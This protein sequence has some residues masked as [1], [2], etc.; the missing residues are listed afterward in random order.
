MEIIRNGRMIRLENLNDE[1][2]RR[3]EAAKIKAEEK[4]KMKQD[5]A[6]AWDREPDESFDLSE[7][8]AILQSN[9]F[10]SGKLLNFPKV[11]KYQKL[12]SLSRWMDAKCQYVRG[13][14]CDAPAKSQKNATVRIDLAIMNILE[15][16]AAKVYAAM[17]A[18]ADDITISGIVNDRK[19]G[20]RCIRV[21]F[22]VQNVWET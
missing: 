20:E 22:C 19:D 15:G 10:F 3:I 6:D 2:G 17:A 4:W 21:S 5:K 8:D 14:S 12:V 1:I 13:F 18:M 16:E 11:E 7:F 9:E